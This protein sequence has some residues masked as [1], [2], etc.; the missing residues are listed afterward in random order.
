MSYLSKMGIREQTKTMLERTFLVR[1]FALNA[2]QKCFGALFSTCLPRSMLKKR[3]QV[4]R[5]GSL[6]FLSDR[7]SQN[8]ELFDLAKNFLTLALQIWLTHA[9]LHKGCQNQKIFCQ[10]KKF[11]VIHSLTHSLTHSLDSLDSKMLWN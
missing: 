2:L 1:P 9:G 8:K 7:Q 3:F 4:S 6:L 10:I 5:Y 11:L